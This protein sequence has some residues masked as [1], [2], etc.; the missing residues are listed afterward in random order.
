M[1]A[2]EKT[3]ETSVSVIRQKLPHYAEGPIVK[4]FGRGSSELGFPTANFDEN[5]IDGLPDQLIG[6]IYWGFAQVQNGP[7]YGM[8]M[9]IG[10]NP[11]YNNTKRA[12]ETHILNKFDPEDLYGQ[13]LRVIIVDFL[14]PESNFQSLQA[15][16]DAIANDIKNA[17]VE[18]GKEEFTRF[19]SDMFFKTD[20]KN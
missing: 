9:S 6:G 12:M 1:G 20:C 5:V 18:M 8:V 16:K 3:C 2:Q 13:H 14:R 11:F 7:V 4:G 10:W 15:L 17:N 19:R